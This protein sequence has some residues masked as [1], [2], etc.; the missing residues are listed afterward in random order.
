M[1]HFVDDPEYPH[2]WVRGSDGPTCTAYVSEEEARKLRKAKR[3]L[4]KDSRQ[5]ILFGGNH[6]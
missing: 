6:E 2:Q 4:R 1:A 3:K 5:G